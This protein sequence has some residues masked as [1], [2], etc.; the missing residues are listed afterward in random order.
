MPYLGHATMVKVLRALIIPFVAIFALLSYYAIQHGTAVAA[1]SYGHGWQIYTAGIAFTVALSGLGWTECGNDYTRYLPRD[2]KKGAIVGWLFL[3][4]RGARDH[5]DDPR[6]VGLLLLAQVRVGVQ[7]LRGPPGSAPHPR[8]GRGGL[9]GLRGRPALRHQ[10]P[11]PLLVGRV[12]PGARRRASSATRRSFWTG[13]RRAPDAVGGLPVDL[14]PVHGRVRRGDHRVDRAVVRHPHRGLDDAQIQATTP[15]SSSAPTR[16]ACTS[17]AG[18][19]PT[20]PDW[21]HSSSGCARR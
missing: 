13:D 5:R 18:R 9:P 17:S 20:G 7:P 11:R 3:G 21:A 12:A 4:H 15:P 16:R 1:Q 14:R 19:A 10:L 2:A 6:R 8:V